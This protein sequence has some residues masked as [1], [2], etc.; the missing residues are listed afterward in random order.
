MI[1]PDSR[2]IGYM[3]LCAVYDSIGRSFG[4]TA[5]A[6]FENQK[7]HN[8]PNSSMPLQLTYLWDSKVVSLFFRDDVDRQAVVDAIERT[9]TGWYVRADIT[10]ISHQRT[11][12]S[13][14]TLE[15]NKVLNDCQG[16]IQEGTRS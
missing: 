12:K 5:Q 11:V 16:A 15:L 9:S 14:D 4:K 8:S 3:T 6:L 1:D 7:C 10:H 2:L 13:Y